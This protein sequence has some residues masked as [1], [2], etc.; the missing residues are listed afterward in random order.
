MRR[1]ESPRGSAKKVSIDA[2]NAARP[3]MTV[4]R[5]TMRSS[6][7]KHASMSRARAAASGSCSRICAW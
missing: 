2:A 4:P 6:A 5:D 3:R 1:A 7:A